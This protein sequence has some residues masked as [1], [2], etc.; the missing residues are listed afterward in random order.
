MDDTDRIH[1][2]HLI[3]RLP[4]VARAFL[5]STPPTAALQIDVELRVD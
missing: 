4:I 5:V 3:D 1:G 2:D